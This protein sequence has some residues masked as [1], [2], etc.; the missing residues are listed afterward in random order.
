MDYK[1]EFKYIFEDN[2]SPKYVNGVYG[3]VGPQGEIIMNFFLERQPIPR[4]EFY[5]IP[6]TNQDP[7][8]NQELIKDGTNPE[9]IRNLFIRHIQSGILFDI[10]HAKIFQKWLTSV[11]DQHEKLRESNKKEG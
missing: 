2:Y 1:I 5:R 9:D 7:E 4:D 3:G 8:T 10:Q 6:E 11:I